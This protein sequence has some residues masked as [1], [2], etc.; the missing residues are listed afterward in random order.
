MKMYFKIL[1]FYLVCSFLVSGTDG[2]IRG[3]VTDDDG[4]ALIGTQIYIPEIEK[5]ATADLDGNF[6][7]LNISIIN[8]IYLLNILMLF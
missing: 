1:Q 4:T 8:I 2:T 3:K 7:I 5:G 6:I